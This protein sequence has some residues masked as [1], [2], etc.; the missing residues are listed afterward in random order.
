[1]TVVVVPSV[2]E[3]VRRAIEAALR[4]TAA[5]VTGDVRYGDPW[6]NAGLQES[7][8]RRD[9]DD[10]AYALSPRRTRGATRA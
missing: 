9:A 2:D 7:V 1:M 6:R 4:A 10:E 5:D 8:G 3:P